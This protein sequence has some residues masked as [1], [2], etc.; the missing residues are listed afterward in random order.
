MQPWHVVHLTVECKSDDKLTYWRKFR[1]F[2]AVV[3]ESVPA[4]S[5]PA[6][7]SHAALPVYDANQTHRTMLRVRLMLP[8]TK[9]TA[10]SFRF[11]LMRRQISAISEGILK[12]SLNV[13]G[14][15]SGLSKCVLIPLADPFWP[16]KMTMNYFVGWLRELIKMQYHSGRWTQISRPRIGSLVAS[17]PTLCWKFIHGRIH[18]CVEQA[19]FQFQCLSWYGLAFPILKFPTTIRPTRQ[20]SSVVRSISV[21]PSSWIYE[22][23]RLRSPSALASS[24]SKEN[25]SE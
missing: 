18:T 7:P 20:V 16:M 10:L 1:A 9:V 3:S 2:V 6:S 8:S 23:M 12:T 25:S 4:S 13:M 21:C 5:V 17:L 22:G 15:D 14:S 11:Y 24:K 19:G